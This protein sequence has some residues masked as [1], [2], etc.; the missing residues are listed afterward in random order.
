MIGGRERSSDERPTWNVFVDRQC[1]MAAESPKSGGVLAGRNA[2]VPP[3]PDSDHCPVPSAFTACT[4]ASYTV[5]D[6]RPE[7]V[8]RLAPPPTTVCFHSSPESCTRY[9]T[10]Y[11]VIRG[12]SFGG[13]FH[14]I[15]NERMGSTRFGSTDG[16]P[17]LPGASVSTSVTVMVTSTLAARPPG[18][19]AVTVSRICDCRS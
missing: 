8:V 13:D 18:S 1:G 9:C 3:K 14:S 6:F 4:C 16:G 15:S 17:G 19:A 5:S 2:N 11:L 12:P 10:V 7:I